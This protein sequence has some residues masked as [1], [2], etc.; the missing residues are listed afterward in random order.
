MVLHQ[1]VNFNDMVADTDTGLFYVDIEAE[2][3]ATGT[4]YNIAIESSLTTANIYAEGVVVRNLESGTAFS[5]REKPY[6]R[7]TNYVNDNN[8]RDSSVAYAVRL[9]YEFT[10]TLTSIQSFVESDDNRIISEDVLVKHFLPG[11][12]SAKITLTGITAAQATTA[13]EDFLATLDP[14]STLEVSDLVKALYDAGATYV[15]LPINLVVITP[16]QDRVLTGQIVQ[17]KV[18]L[19][20][21]RHFILETDGLTVTVTT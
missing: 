10:D 13:V 1:G 2:A 18:P 11:S 7:F 5:T 17:D 20:R 14:A 6:L 12:V 16:S 9:A 19:E 3:A 21:I 15:Q 8:L 4:D